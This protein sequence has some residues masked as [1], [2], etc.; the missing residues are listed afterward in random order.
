MLVRQIVDQFAPGLFG[1]TAALLA[2]MAPFARAELEQ[3]GRKMARNEYFGA[4][5]AKGI[6]AHLVKLYGQ[7]QK[8]AGGN[9]KVLFVLQLW[10]RMAWDVHA[11]PNL[12]QNKKYSK[13]M[14]SLLS[15]M[16]PIT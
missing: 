9:R 8:T 6:L 7:R 5:I 13:G 16:G 4:S 10:P 1:R 2:V 14:P 11:A 12:R 15:N 3:I